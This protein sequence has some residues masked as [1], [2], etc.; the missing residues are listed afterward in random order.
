MIRILLCL[1]PVALICCH[2]QAVPLN[3][4]SAYQ[5]A[6]LLPDNIASGDHFGTSVA[7]DGNIAVVGSIAGDFGAYAF[8]IETGELASSMLPNTRS[9]SDNV[10]RS[11]A[12]HGHTAIVGSLADGEAGGFSGAGFLFDTSSGA[13]LAK[14]LPDDASSGDRFGLSVAIDDG[15]AAVGA[16]YKDA[17]AVYLFDTQTGL[18]LA[19][20][21]S[22]G[23]TT[24]GG[25]GI[26]V[27]ISGD[28]LLVGSNAE[29]DRRGAAYL[30]DLPS[31][32]QVA[33]LLPD[34]REVNSRFGQ[35]VDIDGDSIVVGA[36]TA[37]GGGAAYLFDGSTGQQTH[38]LTPKNAAGS[39]H[40]GIS[41][42]VS[43]GYAVVGTR[44]DAR[45][46]D[47]GG[48]VYVFDTVS[49]EEVEFLVPNDVKPMQEFGISVDIQSNR[50]GVGAWRDTTQGS[51]AGS[52]YLFELVPEPSTA[53]LAIVLA[54]CCGCRRRA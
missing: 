10:T 50:I 18:Q 29:D 25:F 46:A 22:P 38:K 5:T 16:P 45:S 12:V 17:G 24:D 40:F 9:A 27:A 21:S 30:F 31:R 49:G 41:A 37:R 26:S 28:R 2:T 47:F 34:E 14:L 35:V 20:I 23:P 4:L 36:L 51:L 54:G 19:K 3:A 43:D 44:T 1:L 32:T 48:G 7:V 39:Y 15:I 6:K 13:Q 53:C 11:V 52:A 33:Q 8:D 42:A